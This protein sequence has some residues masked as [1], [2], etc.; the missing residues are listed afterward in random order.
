MKRKLNSKLIKIIVSVFF[1]MLIIK[2]IPNIILSNVNED[3]ILKKISQDNNVKKTFIQYNIFDLAEY[4]SEERE[5][6]SISFE[7]NTNKSYLL[8]NEKLQININVKNLKPNNIY[9]VVYGIEENL[10]EEKLQE[11]KTIEFMLEKEGKNECYVA[12][13][14]DGKIIDGAEWKETIY[15]V[16]SYSEQFLDELSKKG[17]CTHY[18]NGTWE[19][20]SKSNELLKALGVKYVRTDFSQTVI[21]RD[22]NTYDFSKYDEW[23]SDLINTSEIQPIILLNGVNAGDDY[24]INSDEE[25]EKFDNFVDAVQNHYPNFSNIEIL[26]EVNFSSNKKGAYLNESDMKWYSKLLNKISL[27]SKTNKFMTAGT[28]STPNDQK[29]I[30]TSTNF[31][32][33]IYNT[34]GLDNINSIAYHPYSKKSNW[35]YSMIKEHR[36]YSNAIGGFNNLNVTEYGYTSSYCENDEEQGKNIL[37]MTVSLEETSNLIVL[38]NLWTTTSNIDS[39]EKYGL[40]NVD[41]TPKESYYIMKKFYEKTN[42][43]EYIGNFQ[44]MDDITCHVYDKDGKILIIA[45]INDENNTDKVCWSDNS[46]V[47]YIDYTN[48]EAYDIYGNEIENTNGKLTIT[49]NPIYIENISERYYFKAINN[50]AISKYDNFLNKYSLILNDEIKYQISENKKILNSLLNKESIDESTAILAMY[51]HFRIGGEL[52][53]L[54]EQSKLS[55]EFVE[56]SSMLDALDEIGNSYEDLVTISAKT[57]NANIDKTKEKIEKVEKLIEENKDLDMIYPNKILKFSKDYYEE[58]EYINGVK[59]ENDIKTGLIVSKN[60]HASLLADWANDF[61]NLYIK[62][63][64]EQNPVTI[65]YS[66]TELTNQNVTATIETTAE[67]QITNNSNSKEHTFEQNG[68][69]TFEYTIKGRALKITATV[70]NI[71]KVAPSI[72]GVQKA[73]LYTKPVTPKIADENLQEI[74]LTLNSQIVSNYKNGDTLEEEGFYELTATDKAG[75]TT[76]TYFQIFINTDTDYKIEENYI[77]N[78]TNNTIKSDFDKKLNLAVNYKITRNGTEISQDEII[79]TGDILTTETGDEYIIIVPGDINKDGKVDLKDF[80]KMRIYLLLENNL[81][82]VEMLAADCNNDNQP[83]GVKDYIRMRLIILMS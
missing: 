7:N 13:K 69:F 17:I 6:E 46:T 10:T 3:N 14:K 70:Q 30:I 74:K 4:L 41:Y 76:S 37:K 28:A 24:L 56:L 21:Q 45:W 49:S 62:K 54:Y 5:N 8:D 34:N 64:I 20:Y 53:E 25:I 52:I 66:T 72:S 71:D 60:L 73:K 19:N 57:R 68:S 79:A 55:I 15:Y 59:E 16:K 48:Y 23:I 18:Q 50:L 77:K 26:N 12:V 78:V 39:L 29:L 43:G 44:L 75:N 67:I 82:E 61:I 63:Y 38:Y 27:H 80:I 81:D 42:G 31:I 58:A 40:L 9:T 33:Y 11:N 36:D 51:N 83:I 32:K 35:F 22:D 1:L 2:I 47:R 65:K